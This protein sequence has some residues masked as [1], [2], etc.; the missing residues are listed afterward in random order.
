MF[1]PF[2]LCGPYSLPGTHQLSGKPLSG[3]RK[4][5]REGRLV[6]WAGKG[7]DWNGRTQQELYNN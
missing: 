4:K 1:R 2:M 3:A 6:G 7:R 5:K